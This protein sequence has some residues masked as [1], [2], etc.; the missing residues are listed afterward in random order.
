MIDGAEPATAQRLRE[1]IGI[2]RI[3]R[4]AAA[5]VPAPIAPEHPVHQRA[6]ELVHPLGLGALLQGDVHRPAHAADELG[7]RE[8]LGRQHAPGD[9]PAAGLA[10]RGHGACLVDVQPDILGRPCHESRSWLRWSMRRGRLHGSSKGR[11]LNMR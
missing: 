11:A 6:Q 4:G 3:A 7:K 5:G 10:H 1:S 2:G 9:H 8:A